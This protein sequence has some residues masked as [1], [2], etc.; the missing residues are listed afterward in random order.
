M[1]VST[2]EL[3]VR[4]IRALAGS[5]DFT[6][7]ES[8]YP[9]TTNSKVVEAEASI[10]FKPGEPVRLKFNIKGS[11]YFLPIPLTKEDAREVLQWLN[12]FHD[13]PVEMARLCQILDV[14]FPKVKMNSEEEKFVDGFFLAFRAFENIDEVWHWHL[15]KLCS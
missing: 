15:H 4:I 7:T 10:V 12:N 9:E 11:V 13:D 2:S 8:Y 1:R 6:L 5:K 14:T 3:F